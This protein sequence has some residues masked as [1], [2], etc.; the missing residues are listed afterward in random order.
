[1]KALKAYPEKVAF[2]LA[3][4]TSVSFI[5]FELFTASPEISGQIESNQKNIK[6]VLE[7][8]IA[9]PKYAYSD[10]ATAKLS[11]LKERVQK[12]QERANR[13]VEAV[14]SFIVYQ[15][16]QKPTIDRATVPIIY[17]VGVEPDFASLGQLQKIEALSDLGRI[18][19]SYE[20]PPMKHMEA[21][22]VEVYRGEGSVEKIDLKTPYAVMDFSPEDPAAAAEAANTKTDPVVAPKVLTGK[23]KRDVEMGIGKDSAKPKDDPKKPTLEIPK[24]FATKKVFTDSHVNAKR[25]YFYTFKLIGRMTKDPGSFIEVKEDKTGKVLKKIIKSSLLQPT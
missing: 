19:V 1:M 14:P 8:N 3:A 7:Q 6:L 18:F 16:P 12:N 4:L 24:E 10:D 15:R 5:A 9:T 13:P 17:E 22:R 21:V 23:E 2:A 11:E 20:L 25:K